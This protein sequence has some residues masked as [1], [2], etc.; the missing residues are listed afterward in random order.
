[1]TSFIK[2]LLEQSPALPGRLVLEVN[3]GLAL[4]SPETITERLE[5]LRKMGLRIALDDFGTGQS[6]LAYLKHFP[7]DIIKLDGFFVHDLGTNYD[8]RNLAQ[9]IIQMGQSLGVTVIAEKVETEAQCEWLRSAGCDHVQGYYTGR[10][11]PADEFTES[12]RG[13]PAIPRKAAQ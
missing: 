6:T 12:V 4:N 13:L 10:P 1:M 9:A 11:V 2:Q 3:E 7:A 8:S 5:R